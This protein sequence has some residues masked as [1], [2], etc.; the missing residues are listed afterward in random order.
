[1]SQGNKAYVVITDVESG[2]V[3]AEGA[4]VRFS[5]VVLAPDNTTV[6]ATDQTA[7]AFAYGDSEHGIQEL[8]ANFVRTR[9]G[10][11]NLDVNFITG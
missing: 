7:T 9:T 3:G 8:I 2:T 4:S 1:M 5:F 11:S 10:D 6:V